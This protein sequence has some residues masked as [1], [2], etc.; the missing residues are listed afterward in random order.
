MLRSTLPEQRS[1]RR[2]TGHSTVRTRATTTNAANARTIFILTLAAWG[3]IDIINAVGHP[4]DSLVKTLLLAFL[5]L[6][7]FAVAQ[8]SRH[9]RSGWLLS[10]AVTLG[11]AIASLYDFTAVVITPA[12]AATVLVACIVLLLTITRGAHTSRPP[13]SDD[14]AGSARGQRSYALGNRSSVDAR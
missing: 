8:R 13:R 11:L 3:L 7:C 2:W 5:A 9:H 14:R 4:W 12:V 6:G 1:R 10:S